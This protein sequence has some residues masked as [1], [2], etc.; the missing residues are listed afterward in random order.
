MNFLSYAIILELAF[1]V[2]SLMGINI[3]INKRSR[4]PNLSKKKIDKL[5][6]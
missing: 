6:F 4:Q 3:L 2:I 1:I 5:K